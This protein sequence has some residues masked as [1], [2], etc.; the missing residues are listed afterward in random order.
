MLAV[1]RNLATRIRL[2]KQLL[3][4]STSSAFKS[5]WDLVDK[6]KVIQSAGF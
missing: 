1:Y 3:D 2:F 5:N 6:G 4:L